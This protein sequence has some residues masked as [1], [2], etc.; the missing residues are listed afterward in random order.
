VGV[1]D[2]GVAALA[3][4]AGAPAPADADQ[5]EEATSPRARGGVDRPLRPV[6]WTLAASLERPARATGRTAR[7]EFLHGGLGTPVGAGDPA[8][9][10]GGGEPADAGVSRSRPGEG[11]AAPE[12]ACG[13][14]TG[15]AVG[16]LLERLS[17]VRD[18]ASRLELLRAVAAAGTR[19]ARVAL[20]EL[21]YR[22]PR[23]LDRRLAVRALAESPE[24]ASGRY[25]YQIA[26]A[27]PWAGIRADAVR[28]MGRRDDERVVS[29]LVDV[30]HEDVTPDVQKT[31]VSTLARVGGE[32]ARSGLTRIAG[33]HPAR[34]VRA[35]ALY[36][37]IRLDAGEALSRFVEA[38]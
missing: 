16:G 28:R 18:T 37:L 5:R 10:P 20:M 34:E 21:S 19:P 33:S 31:A 13:A 29:W 35:E 24:A 6:P 38:T 27:N 23:A 2:G 32:S 4:K 26:R 11:E 36:W 17:A 1:D 25:L 3:R 9:T 30:A 8:A 12:I 15:C 7:G 14:A 22:A